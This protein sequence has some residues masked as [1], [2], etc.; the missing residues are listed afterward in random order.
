MK[1]QPCEAYAT[2]PSQYMKNTLQ[3]KP[4]KTTPAVDLNPET[5]IL[6][7]RGMSIPENVSTFYAPILDWLRAYT[8]NPAERTT[9]KFTFDYFNTA[10]SKVLMELITVLESIHESSSE[11]V[12]E[13]H[14]KANDPDMQEAGEDYALITRVPFEFFKEQ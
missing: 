12:I 8:Q 3:I 14:Y 11:C 13:W 1:S 4:T 2:V 9:L 6:G 7:L 10:T 5:G